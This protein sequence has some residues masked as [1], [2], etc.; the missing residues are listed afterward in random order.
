MVPHTPFTERRSPSP[1]NLVVSLYDVDKISPF[2]GDAIE[3]EGEA[4]VE[5]G[6]PVNREM[7]PASAGI[8]GLVLRPSP[9][10]CLCI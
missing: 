6:A 3:V 8:A 4:A 5:V 7:P 2:S 1:T 9:V 10:S